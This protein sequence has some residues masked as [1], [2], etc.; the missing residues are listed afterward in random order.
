M[1]EEIIQQIVNGSPPSAVNS[2]LIAHVETFSPLTEIRELPSIW[3]VFC[4]QTVL[5]VIV[6]TL[7]V[8]SMAKAKKWEQLFTDGTSC[9]QV[10]CQNL[11]IS[12]EEDEL[13]K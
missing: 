3:T 2:N 12:T 6:K 10:A 5:L 7:A 11:I 4:A 1:W 9:R 13:F 8:Y